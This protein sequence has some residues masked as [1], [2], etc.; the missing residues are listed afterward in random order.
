MS[1]A[2]IV[3]VVLIILALLAY[4]ILV[5]AE[6]KEKVVFYMDQ[7]TK[8]KLVKTT[9]E[10]ITFSVEI[11]MKNAGEDEGVILDAYVRPYLCQEQYEG[12]LMRG[13]VNLKSAPRIDD[14][15]PCMLT[16]PTLDEVLVLTFDVTPL[17]AKD[18]KEAVKGLPDLDVALFVEQRGRQDLY[19]TKK[20]FTLSR[21][22][23]RALAA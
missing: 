1:T 22:E 18:A 9:P 16:P 14:Y 21:E 10:K 7:R 20:I 11:P 13:K 23:L 17:K 6:G 4:A 19:T 2:I 3:I 15:F 5:K 8:A 12:A